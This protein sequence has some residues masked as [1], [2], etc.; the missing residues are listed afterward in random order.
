MAAKDIAALPGPK[1]K[2]P[3]AGKEPAQA[4]QPQVAA[5]TAKQR[6]RFAKQQQGNL[7][8]AQEQ[9]PPVLVACKYGAKCLRLDMVK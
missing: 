7:Q 4:P 8:A 5:L 3:A 6:K 9:T 2:G 1:K